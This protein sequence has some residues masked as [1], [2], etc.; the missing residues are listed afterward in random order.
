MLPTLAK[1]KFWLSWIVITTVTTLQFPAISLAQTSTFCLPKSSHV[2]NTLESACT[3][4]IVPNTPALFAGNAITNAPNA[5][6]SSIL[7]ARSDAHTSITPPVIP[8]TLEVP[9]FTAISSIQN[10]AG[11]TLSAI[12]IC[13]STTLLFPQPSSAA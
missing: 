10:I 13:T 4:G 11:P 8:G 9:R 6:Q 1:H 5:L 2:N 7:Q 12:T 3:G